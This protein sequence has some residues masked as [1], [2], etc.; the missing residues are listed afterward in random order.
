MVSHYLEL[1]YIPNVH[2]GYKDFLKNEPSV[3]A[4]LMLESGA[5]SA[6]EQIKGVKLIRQFKVC[7]YLVDGYDPVGNVC[8]EIDED[9]HTYRMDLDKKR[10]KE[11]TK[12]STRTNWNLGANSYKLPSHCLFVL[13]G[14]KQ[15]EI[16]AEQAKLL[17]V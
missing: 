1:C 14:A 10:E 17:T 13:C 11:I 16:I 15:T 2:L 9:H 3:R 12:K 4:H 6:I 5:L 7:G 8:Y